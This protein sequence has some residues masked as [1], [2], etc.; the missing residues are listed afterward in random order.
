MNKSTGRTVVVYAASG[1]S[2]MDKT[3]SRIQGIPGKGATVAD[4]KV[5]HA[6]SSVRDMEKWLKDSGI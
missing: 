6:G 2:L 3:S 1:G 5:Q 4:G